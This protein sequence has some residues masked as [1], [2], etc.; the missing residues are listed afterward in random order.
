MR[1]RLG[2]TRPKGP[3][4][5][6]AAEAKARQLPR[7][8]AASAAAA[9]AAGVAGLAR[10]LSREEPDES[11]IGPE[12]WGGWGRPRVPSRLP[13]R[14][15]RPAPEP[16]GGGRVGTGRPDASWAAGGSGSASRVSTARPPPALRLSPG[17]RLARQPEPG[18][19]NRSNVPAPPLSGSGPRAAAPTVASPRAVLVTEYVETESLRTWTD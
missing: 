3:A 11:P 16:A 1:A 19:W 13:A 2:V 6:R 18:L 17:F 5:A 8:A 4:A 9:A 15:R 12:A 10:R 7:A 14:A